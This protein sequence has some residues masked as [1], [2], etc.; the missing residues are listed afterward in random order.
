MVTFMTETTSNTASTT[1]LLNFI[2]AGV[3][4]LV[5]WGGLAP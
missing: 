2:A 1:L 3:I 4:A 5:C